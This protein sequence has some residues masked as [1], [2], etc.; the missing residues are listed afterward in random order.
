MVRRSIASRRPVEDRKSLDITWS[1]V[2]VSAFIWFPTTASA[3]SKTITI[4]TCA[5]LSQQAMC[6]LIS[7]NV[8]LIH[9]YYHRILMSSFVF[10]IKLFT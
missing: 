3:S 2:L 5:L 1:V 6:W 9:V 10:C 4:G 7:Y 8:G